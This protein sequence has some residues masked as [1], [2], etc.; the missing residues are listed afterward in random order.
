ML[1]RVADAHVNARET[2]AEIER[3]N[4]WQLLCFGALSAPLAMAGLVVAIYVP[5]FYAVELGL[6][7]G[8]VGFVFAAGRVLDVVTDPV[9]GYYSDQTRSRCGP[10]RPWMMAG[11]PCFCIATLALLAP[12]DGVGPLYL[13][14]TSG[15]YFLFFTAIDVPYSSV[16]LE[17]STHNHERSLLASYKAVFQVV[18]SILAAALPVFLALSIPATLPFLGKL[19]MG[20]SLFGLALFLLFVPKRYQGVGKPTSGIFT[21]IKLAFSRSSYRTLILAFFIVQSA[22]ALSVTL[23]VLFVTHVIQAPNLIGLFIAILLISSAAGLPIWL[24]LAKRHNKI[25]TWRV[26]I[27]VCCCCLA[28]TPFLSAGDNSALAV[29]CVLLGGALG[30]D[31]VMPTSLLADIVHTDE[32]HGRS[33]LAGLYLA[34]KNAVSKMAFVVPMGLAFPLLDLAGLGETDANGPMQL[35]ALIFFFGLLPILLRIG[36]FVVLGRRPFVSNKRLVPDG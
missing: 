26:S 22:N 35:G 15:L 3:L 18:G 20:G 1:D 6:G 23:T 30:C 2:D 9:I 14:V 32:Q 4:L 27:L 28:F 17:I 29:V 36:A 8:L 13:L 24:W 31:A 19:I 11:V 34:I 5:T 16:G 12:P 21:T 7:L 10:R 25:F 33:R